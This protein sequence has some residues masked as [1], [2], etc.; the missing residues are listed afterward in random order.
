[1]R[2]SKAKKIEY[3]TLQDGSQP[4]IEWIDEL[5]N[6]TGARVKASI[7]KVRI[8]LKKNVE[9]L[10]DGVFEIK[11]DF[12]PG[13]RVYFGEDGDSL[14]LLICGGD[15]SSQKK[16]IQRAKDLWR[17]YEKNKKL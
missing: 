12:G 8:G 1:M 7:E 6:K 2:F 13:Y 4:I 3:L 11:M 17:E 15:K 16:D 5:D 14:I 10:K 9:A